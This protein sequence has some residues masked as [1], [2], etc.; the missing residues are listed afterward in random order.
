MNI[1]PLDDRVVIKAILKEEKTAS[2]IVLP[3]NAGE[4]KKQE[5]EVVA[6]GPGKLLENGSRAP[7]QVQVGQRVLV[8]S[9][10]GDDVKVDGEEY[11]ILS[12]EDILAILE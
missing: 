8:K 10:G 9:W 12:Q 3:T 11:K 6:I 2:G 1:K 4:K 7:M 5:A